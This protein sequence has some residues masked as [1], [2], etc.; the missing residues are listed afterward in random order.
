MSC[1]DT[2]EESKKD[3]DITR[4]LQNYKKEDNKE[5]KLLLLGAGGCGKC[6][7]NLINL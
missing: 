2:S 1:F 3:K 6:N 4:K 5:I 7:F